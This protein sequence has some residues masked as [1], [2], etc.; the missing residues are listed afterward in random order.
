MQEWRSRK[1]LTYP[2]DKLTGP[3]FYNVT[4][5]ETFRKF[6][7]VSLLQNTQFPEARWLVFAETH[8]AL[9]QV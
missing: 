4:L 1:D 6:G 2:T 7:D 8:A 3:C 5:T 9:A